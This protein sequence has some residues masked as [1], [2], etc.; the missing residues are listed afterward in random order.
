MNYREEKDTMGTVRV[1]EDAYYGAQTQRAADNFHIS[2]MRF[3]RSFIQALGLIKKQAALVNRELGLLDPT[4]AEAIVKAAEETAEGAHDTE[5]VIDV[6]QT[7]SG[8]STNMNANEVIGSRAN[9]LITGKRGGKTPVHPNDHVNMG[10][11][12]NDVIPSVIH[13]AAYLSIRERLT[14]ALDRLQRGLAAKATEFADVRKI[15]RTHLRDAIP[16]TLGREFGG[17]GRQIE[18]AGERVRSTLER[19]RELALGGTA[20]GT[21]ANTHPEFARMVIEGLAG[22]TGCP[23][24][25]ATDHFEA[26]AAQDAAVE[27]SGALRTVAVSLTKIC[28]DIRWL[29]SGPRCSIGEIDIPSL[30]PGSSIM[31][32][33]VN[34]VIPEAVLMVAAQVMGNDLTVSVAG[35]A[36]NFELNVMLPVIA[37][38]LLQSI[39]LLSTAAAELAEKCVDGITANRER[40]RSFLEQSLAMAT[41]LAPAVGYDRAAGVAKKA[42]AEGITV[43]EAAREM[44]LL[45]PDELDRLLDDMI[46]GK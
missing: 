29:S 34:P 30:Q 25:E 42:Y 12:S 24:V 28:N 4:L 27:T 11:S 5:F 32:G 22:E 18:L 9:E 26:Q 21:G 15:G 39:E 20:V 41:A 13:V 33:K 14:P 31:P 2:G 35:S 6:F 44:D 46:E 10:Q 8:T 23:F 40:A 36:G 19:L 45:P 37:F 17:Y 7:G 43:R 3:G 1:P 38:N 16:M